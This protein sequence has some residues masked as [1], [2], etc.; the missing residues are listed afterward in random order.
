MNAPQLSMDV[1]LPVRPDGQEPPRE[2]RLRV[3]ARPDHATAILL[4]RL[5]LELPN[6]PKFAQN[7]AEKNAL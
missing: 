6:A 3:V 1:I 2:L 7:V 5:N 4:H